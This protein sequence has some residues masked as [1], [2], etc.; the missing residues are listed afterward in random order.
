MKEWLWVMY[1]ISVSRKGISSLHLVEQ[2]NRPKNTTCSMLERLK[3]VFGNKQCVLNGMV[4]N[5]ETYHSGKE[6]NKHESKK[7]H[8]GRGSIGKQPVHGIRERGGEVV[9]KPVPYADVKNILGN[10]HKHVESGSTVF[11]DEHRF[12]AS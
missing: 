1:K 5:D 9:A 4:E 12:T 10:I 2:L 11:T 7:L 8:A 6:K 3:E